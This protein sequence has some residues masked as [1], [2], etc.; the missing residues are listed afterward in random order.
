MKNIAIKNILDPRAVADVFESAKH[1]QKAQRIF[2]NCRK[3]QKPKTLRQKI[4]AK[5][6]G[7]YES[8]HSKFW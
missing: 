3:K 5:L 2:E 1:N 8:K 6:K 7:I 4:M